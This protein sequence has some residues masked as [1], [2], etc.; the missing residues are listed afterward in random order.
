MVCLAENGF[1]GKIDEISKTFF[2]YDLTFCCL[3]Y[4]CIIFIYI[5]FCLL[6]LLLLLLILLSCL[7]SLFYVKDLK[8]WP[9]L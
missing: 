4:N 8:V 7:L 3:T 1:Q 6:L 9:L 5:S 2:L